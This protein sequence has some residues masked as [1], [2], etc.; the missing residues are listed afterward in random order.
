[1][2]E[3]IIWTLFC[4]LKI[5]VFLCWFARIVLHN[6]QVILCSFKLFC[7]VHF[8]FTWKSCKLLQ[9]ANFSHFVQ[10]GNNMQFCKELLHIILVDT[11]QQRAAKRLDFI[12]S[13]FD[14]LITGNKKIRIS[15]CIYFFCLFYYGDCYLQGKYKGI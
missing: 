11:D 10:L 4:S 13:L 8:C 15:A 6:T 5:Y 2:E 9:H 1:M 3:N 14:F 7:C 12:F